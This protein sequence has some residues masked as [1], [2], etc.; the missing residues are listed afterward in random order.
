[1]K[2]ASIGH[3]TTRELINQLPND[4]IGNKYIISPEIDIDGTKG[5]IFIL[6]LTASQMMNNPRFEIRKKILECMEYAYHTYDIDLIQ[7]GALTTSV[8]SG[9][10]WI[11]KQD[12]Y[13]G[14][15]NHGDSYTAAIAAQNVLD[16][17]NLFGF[18][19]EDI[20][21]GIIGAYGIIGEAM[22]TLL[23]PLFKE[24]VLI[25]RRQEKLEE[26]KQKIKGN[27][28]ITTS[29]DTIH[30]DIIV[31]ATSHPTALL[32]TDHLKKNAII[33]D[34]S[35]PQNLTEEVCN[36]RPDIHRID[37]GLVRFPKD[38]VIPTLP[39]GKIL[40]CIAEIIMQAIENEKQNHVGSIDLSH[41]QKTQQWG[42][43]YGFVLDELTNFGKPIKISDSKV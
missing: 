17:L 24:T 36:Q 15:V 27:I 12:D 31:T 6:K 14:Y 29:L 43:K 35:Q 19:P 23:S 22:S 9:G 1:M 7:L 38:F 5:H 18:L 4:W 13:K 39:K 32:T 10:T 28:R 20:N 37:G 30:S 40:S 2:F 11:V 41:L 34:I 33:I 3:L 16:S 26:L 21:L 8:T 25:G 42:K